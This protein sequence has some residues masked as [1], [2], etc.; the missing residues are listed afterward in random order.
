MFNA[1]PCDL[2]PWSSYILKSFDSVLEAAVTRS[3]GSGPSSRRFA[4]AL[5]NG[6]AIDAGGARAAGDV[7]VA[8]RASKVLLKVNVILFR[9]NSM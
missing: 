2:S 9:Y 6:R 1:G 5:E 8:G 7:I 3:Y 4:V